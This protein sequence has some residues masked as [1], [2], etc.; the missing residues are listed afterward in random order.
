[1]SVAPAVRGA[2]SRLR[3]RPASR[4]ARFTFVAA[5]VASFVLVIL[6]AAPDAQAPQQPP[7]EGA[8]GPA[9]AAGARPAEASRPTEISLL[10]GRSTVLD[11]GRPIERVSVTTAEVA[12]ALVTGPQQLLIHGKAPGTIS[13]FV[14]DRSGRVEAFD[15]RVRRDLTALVDQMRQLFPG[16]PIAVAGNGKD[17]VLSGTVS[18]RYIVEKAAEVAAGYVDGKEHVV[19]LLRQQEGVATTQVMLRVRFAEVSRSA[20]QELGASVF[21]DHYRQ[22]VARISTEQFPAPAFDQGGADLGKT[23]VFSDYLNLFLF[24]ARNELGAVIRALQSRGLFQSLAEPNLIAQNGVEASFLAGG[25]FPYPVV[26]G[27]GGANLAVTIQFKEFGVRLS[28]TPTILGEDLIRL[29]VRPEVSAL[30]FTNAVVVQGFR[31]PALST[32]RTE[33]EVELQ[34][35]QTFAIAGLLNNTVTESLQKVPGIGDIPIL[36][37]LFRSRAHQKQQTEL[38]VMITPQIVKRG[39]TGVASAIPALATPFLEPLKKPVAPPPPYAPKDEAVPDQA[40]AATP[41]ETAAP[42]RP[43]LHGPD[44]AGLTQASPVGGTPHADG[45]ARG[46][47][48][49]ARADEV[50][51][52]REAAERAARDERKR[53]AQAAKMEAE[54]AKREAEAATRAAEA[55]RRRQQA[56]QAAAKRQAEREAR[57]REARAKAEHER[58][59][60]E[61]KAARAAARQAEALERRRAELAR[62]EAARAAEAATRAAKAADEARRRAEASAKKRRE[63]EAKR[64]RA[65]EE[66]EARVRAA[67]D[68][69]ASARPKGGGT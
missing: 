9:F 18:S 59:A 53:A 64:A 68:R 69:A 12:D 55:A 24:D 11:V 20:L 5:L 45:S 35:G 17:I 50:K 44:V 34:N 52:A 37:L 8:P 58:A 21:A 39:S 42:V 3:D 26:Q 29:K 30:D 61:A 22:R 2:A 31:I 1:M 38:V 32:R 48:E 27:T 25:E 23:L 51:R 13:L 62:E 19:N 36:G 66:A 67:L 15:V 63:E 56:E 49:G 43:A 4:S 14:W 46:A 65:I 60:R 47:R 28:F 57:E 54:A 6:V 7:S 40:R 33:T 41:P 16:E 10:V